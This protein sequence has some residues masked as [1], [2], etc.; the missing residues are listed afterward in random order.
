MAK[1]EIVARISGS[2]DGVDWPAVGETL[3]VPAEEA[4][5]LVR[6]GFARIVEV[7]AVKEPVERAVAPKAETRKV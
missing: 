4:A 1:I 5:D 7:K 3:T 6:L 2:R